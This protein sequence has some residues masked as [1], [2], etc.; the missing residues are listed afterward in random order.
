VGDDEHDESTLHCISHYVYLPTW[1]IVGTCHVCHRLRF[2]R[3]AL[4]SEMFGK[5]RPHLRKLQCGG[6]AYECSIC[7]SP[8]NVYIP[9]V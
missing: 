5:M 9:L 4:R 8:R 7:D 2:L 6:V 1:P 3:C